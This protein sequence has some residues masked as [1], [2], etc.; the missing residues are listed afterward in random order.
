[1]SGGALNYVYS[2]VSDAAFDV[3]AKSQ[4]PLHRAFAAH[5]LRVS[6]ALH[7]LE[8]VLSDDSAPGSEVAAIEAC[9]GQHALLEQLIKEAREAQAALSA[10]LERV[11]P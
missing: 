1:M 11:K 6:H 4:T 7:D 10:E 8:W 2:R 5:L 3:S 9:L